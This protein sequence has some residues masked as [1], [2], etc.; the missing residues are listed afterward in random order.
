MDNKK[1]KAFDITLFK[2][3]LHYIRPY[4]LVFLG[5]LIC[6]IG[7]AV[8]GML[9]PIV[10]QKAIDEHIALKVYYGF[11]FYILAMLALFVNDN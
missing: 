10:L 7:L 9:R 2:R 11:L 3:L 1:T 8:F 6:V 4:K 5:S